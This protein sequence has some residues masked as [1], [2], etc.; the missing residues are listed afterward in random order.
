MKYA[1]GEAGLLAVR[2]GGQAVPTSQY[3]AGARRT[4]CPWDHRVGAAVEVDRGR[5]V[6]AERVGGEEA[7]VG[8]E[9]HQVAL[10][11]VVAGGGAEEDAAVRRHHRRGGRLVEDETGPG[12]FSA[13]STPS[14]APAR[15]PPGAPV[16]G[17]VPLQPSVSRSRSE[18]A[19]LGVRSGLTAMR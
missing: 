7:A 4:G 19:H 17:I 8:R 10:G 6:P 9:L 12:R 16:G 18:V 14:W 13:G 2:S 11:V 5:G 1:S 15:Q 3:G